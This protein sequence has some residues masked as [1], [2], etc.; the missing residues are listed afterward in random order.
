[1]PRCRIAIR[2]VP[3]PGVTA[4]NVI[5]N[6]ALTVRQRS[7]KI[8]CGGALGALQ[9]WSMAA[10]NAQ[11][12]HRG[13]GKHVVADAAILSCSLICRGENRRSLLPYNR[14]PGQGPRYV[15]NPASLAKQFAATVCLMR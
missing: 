10:S 7:V 5:G 13:R 6:A 12:A 8:G 14:G 2:N 3:P 9:A 11:A 1:M 4:R 15:R